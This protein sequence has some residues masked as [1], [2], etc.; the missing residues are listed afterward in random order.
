MLKMG[1]KT[2]KGSDL[3]IIGLSHMNLDRLREGRPIHCTARDFGFDSDA[4]ILI[5]SGETEQ[6][7]A[8]DMA[9]LVGPNTD[10]K[11]D[12]RLRD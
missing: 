1:A 11:I 6:S 9:E 10:V 4:E 2:K 12:P 3:I 5:F 8:R 7:M